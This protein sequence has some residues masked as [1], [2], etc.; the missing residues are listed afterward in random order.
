MSATAPLDTYIIV[1][2]CRQAICHRN[3]VHLRLAAVSH[4][5]KSSADHHPQTHMRTIAA[6]L[7]LA[8]DLVS[9]ECLWHDTISKPSKPAQTK[10]STRAAVQH[11]SAPPRLCSRSGRRHGSS[12]RGWS[13]RRAQALRSDVQARSGRRRPERSSLTRL[14]STQRSPRHLSRA[15][16]RNPITA[17]FARALPSSKNLC[18]ATCCRASGEN[19]ADPRVC[20][21]LAPERNYEEIKKLYDTW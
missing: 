3:W 14:V 12:R 8:Q 9:R 15:N 16:A 7:T 2:M 6:Q 13:Q 18:E 5:A 10:V 17:D 19:R 11:R 1:H 4:P 20:K 21:P